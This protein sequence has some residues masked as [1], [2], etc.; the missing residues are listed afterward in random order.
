MTS[1]IDRGAGAA[2]RTTGTEP[3]ASISPPAKVEEVAQ[4]SGPENLFG[5]R[6]SHHD[7]PKGEGAAVSNTASTG[8][9]WGY[10][11]M[12]SSKPP[13]SAIT[14]KN[15]TPEQAKAKLAEL[16]K[17]KEALALRIAGRQD[18][19]DHQWRTMVLTRRTDI[20]KSYLK[21]T[22]SLTHVQREKVEAS[23]AKSETLNARI[24][25][26]LAQ[27]DTLLP[28]PNGKKGTPEQRHE[29]AVLI[30]EARRQHQIAVD[31]GTAS[32]DAAG[33]KLERLT[34]TENDIDP[35]G[36]ASSPHG[37]MSALVGQY[38]EVCFMGQT[39]ELVFNGPLAAEIKELDREIAEAKKREAIE[40][41]WRAKD[42]LMRRLL[43]ELGLKRR[44]EQRSVV[45]VKTR[46]LGAMSAAAAAKL[47]AE[48]KG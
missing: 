42:E 23:I 31:E 16:E 9:L 18:E 5:A 13:L 43:K 47:R 7:R 45:A 14:L 21:E 30:W 10:E 34:V 8:R 41:A 40:D 4:K 36:G 32:I 26:L 48:S 44:A 19:L 24:E 28:Q 2:A 15:L 39:L 38:F 37:S 35:S 17:R 11:G 1:K 29:L 12:A 22:S 6:S 27:I 33:L 25:E 3:A 46:D 20:L